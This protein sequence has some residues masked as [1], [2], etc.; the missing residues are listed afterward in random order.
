M[1]RYYD[2]DI[3]GK[4]WFAVQSSSDADFFGV[5]GY[6]P[7]ELHYDFDKEENIDDVKEGIEKCKE[8]L[9]NYKEKFDDIF[10]TQNRGYNFETLAEELKI[11]DEEVKGLLKWYARL[12]LGEKILNCL[13][14]NGS[15]SFVAEC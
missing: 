7:S 6:T 10:N 2:G 12:E 13:E 9:G 11:T 8:A 4:F 5:E 15:C 1:G 3:E 14:Q